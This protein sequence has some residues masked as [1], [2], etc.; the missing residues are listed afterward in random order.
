M[1][2]GSDKNSDV[3]LNVLFPDISVQDKTR[4]I[5]FAYKKL[6][7]RISG[8]RASQFGSRGTFLLEL[9]ACQWAASCRPMGIHGECSLGYETVYLKWEQLI[10]AHKCSEQEN[11]FVSHVKKTNINA[12]T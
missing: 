5:W 2:N 12:P 6:S 1:L 11:I 9:A 3:Q 10:M 8:P 4:S 7:N